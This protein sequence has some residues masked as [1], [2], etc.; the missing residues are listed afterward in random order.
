MQNFFVIV[1]SYKKT[2]FFF[3]HFNYSYA[4]PQYYWKFT[5]Y[6]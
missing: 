1:S 3:N 6:S 5:E 2:I 4:S